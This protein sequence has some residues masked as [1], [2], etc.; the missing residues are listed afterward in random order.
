M[1]TGDVAKNESSVLAVNLKD[2]KKTRESQVTPA[3]GG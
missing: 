1:A 2:Q 3:F